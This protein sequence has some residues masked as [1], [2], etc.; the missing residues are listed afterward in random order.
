MS[1]VTHIKSRWPSVLS[2][3]YGSLLTPLD[4]NKV[5]SVIHQRFRQPPARQN[6]E[7]QAPKE[8]DMRLCVSDILS[9]NYSVLEGI[10][11][12][13]SMTKTSY[14]HSKSGRLCQRSGLVKE[15]VQ[16][17]NKLF[18]SCGR[19]SGTTLTLL[20]LARNS[21]SLCNLPPHFRGFLTPTVLQ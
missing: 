16:N 21:G 9:I 20:Q 6:A 2:T 19:Q 15:D 5:N 7:K 4:T 3:L 1:P 13:N 12:K 17:D 14:N 18:F 11:G 10:Q 8:K